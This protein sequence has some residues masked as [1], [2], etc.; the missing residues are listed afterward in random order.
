MSQRKPLNLREKRDIGQV[1]NAAFA[2]MHLSY[3]KMFRDL[4][5]FAT[6][7]YA[8]AG[9]C[10]SIVQFDETAEFAGYALGYFTNPLFYAALI[11]GFVATTMSWGI[12][13]NY[14]YQYNETG[15]NQF[16][17]A[18]ILK[19]F[20][21]QL[22]AVFAVSVIYVLVNLGCLVFFLI[23]GLYFSIANA[24]AR[25]GYILE[26]KSEEQKLG[27]GDSFGESRRLVS[28]NWWR[29]FGLFYIVYF[30]VGCIGVIF[31]IPEGI[32]KFMVSFNTARGVDMEGY[33]IYYILTAALSQVMQGLLEPI[34]I[35]AL[36]IYYFSLKESK[37]Q[38]NLMANIENIGA[39]PA[40][41]TENEGS[42]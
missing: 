8:I 16:D 39:K 34:A 38:T 19:R 24:M 14:I 6:P 17:K 9:I 27:V 41:S 35:T 20:W 2:F 13:G 36:F 31:I 1:V 10:M 37:D 33:R 32:L 7:F 40:S 5:L 28:D 15:S 12:V 25:P 23:P 29:T 42:Y 22:P 30:L 21:K 4:I 26:N 3:F 18:A 11:S